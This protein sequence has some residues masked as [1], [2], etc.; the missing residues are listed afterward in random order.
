[1]MEIALQDLPGRLSLYEAVDACYAEQI[2]FTHA[3]L[4]EGVPVLVRCEKQITPFLQ[5][6]LKKRLTADGKS[7]TILDGRAR[8]PDEEGT[9]R[10]SAMV[11]HLCSLIHN[12]EAE[13]VFFL[14]YLDI[15]TSAMT[16]GVTQECR[17]IMTVIHE[18]P[19][20]VMAAFEE[21]IPMNAEF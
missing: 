5:T 20:L 11:T 16:G 2:R 19:F 15:L 21:K 6:I 3:R 9:S 13:K 17:E 8:N 14:P 7:V 10:V 18:N 4:R 1:M 12:T